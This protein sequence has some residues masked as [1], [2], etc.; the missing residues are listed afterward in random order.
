[1]N[2]PI[3]FFDGVCN[4]CH[5][6]VQFVIRH[7]RRGVIRFASLQSRAGKAAVAAVQQRYGRVP[8]SLIFLDGAEYFVESDAALHVAHYLDGGWKA[9]GWLRI[10]PRFLRNAVYRIVARYRYRWFG[11]QDACMLPTPALKQRF[12]E[13]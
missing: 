5:G 2:G 12:L 8:D 1:M 9:L 13:D 11:R 7:D 10:F 4:L 6:A 3:L